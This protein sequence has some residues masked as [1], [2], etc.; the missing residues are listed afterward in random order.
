MIKQKKKILFVGENSQSYSGFSKYYNNVISR[1]HKMDKYEIAELASYATIEDEKISKVDWRFYPNSVSNK[2]ARHKQYMS[3]P[4]NQF[5]A[6]RFEKTL[7][8]FKPDIVFSCRDFWYDTFLY[9]SPLRPFYHLCVMPTCDSAPISE[10]WLENLIDADSLFA[11][12]EWSGNEMVKATFDQCKYCGTAPPAI[13]TDIFSPALNKMEQKEKCY[14]DKDIYLV[15][16]VGRN[17]VRKLFPDLFIAFKYFLEWCYEKCNDE[18]ANKTYLFLHTSM[19]DINPWNI[20]LL[21]KEL[22]ISHKVLFSYIC[23]DCDQWF[24]AIYSDTKTICPKCGGVACMPNVEVGVDDKQL[25]EIYKCLDLY[26][27][28]ANCEGFGIPLL[29][30]AA[31]GKYCI[32]VDYSAMSTIIRKV[33]GVPIRPHGMFREINIGAWR[34]YPNNGTLAHEMYEFLSLPQNEKQKRYDMARQGVLKHYS[35]DKTASILESHF[36]QIQLV[37]LQ[38]KWNSP[39]RFIQPVEINEEKIEQ[40]DNWQFVKFIIGK[41]L[42]KPQDIYRYSTMHLLAVL[43]QGVEIKDKSMKHITKK[44]VLN[45]A[46]HMVNEHNA[47]E[48]VRCGLKPLQVE[49]FMVY[50]EL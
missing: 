47:V 48:E 23:R 14:F 27:Q 38:G 37:D 16:M 28:Y 26:V 30:A 18:L 41:V 33:K 20:P 24:P 43:N 2:D 44:D 22:N 15:G 11:Y 46:L 6:W 19:P 8:H 35:W 36:D 32:A 21:L 3:N 39:P 31:C 17:Q 25:A 10:E 1:L 34:A 50:G 40:M 12:T 4:T 13:D 42:N 49:D 45:G 29:E 5:G 9:S 7:L